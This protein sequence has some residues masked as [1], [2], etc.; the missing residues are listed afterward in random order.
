MSVLHTVLTSSNLVVGTQDEALVRIQQSAFNEVG[1][2]S[3]VSTHP[4]N[5]IRLTG[6]R[7]TVI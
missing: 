7:D 1:L 4:F 3:V 6:R 2:V 5:L